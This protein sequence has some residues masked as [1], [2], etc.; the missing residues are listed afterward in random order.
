[1]TPQ[2]PLSLAALRRGSGRA[3][4]VAMLW[5]TLIFYVIFFHALANLD[6]DNSPLVRK[7]T[8]HLK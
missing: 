3:M 6:L 4:A 1:M 7:V 8:W 2:A 5:A